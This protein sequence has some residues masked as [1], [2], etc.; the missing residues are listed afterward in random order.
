M[1]SPADLPPLP[2]IPTWKGIASMNEIERALLA[3]R[4]KCIDI[5]RADLE[6][7]VEKLQRFKDFAHGRLDEGGIPQDPPGEHRDAGCRIG[8][9]LDLIFSMLAQRDER[10][11]ELEHQLIL[12]N[13]AV[14]H[15]L[16]GWQD[17]GKRAE[18]AEARLETIRKLVD[19]QAEDDGLWFVAEHAPEAYL[20]QE[21]RKLHALIEENMD[22]TA[23]SP[24]TTSEGRSSGESEVGPP[25]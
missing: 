14:A 23:G 5:A 10:I 8:Q 17:E 20:Q 3:W 25:R 7:E 11:K 1:I 12:R 21:L 4:D 2:A 19:E 18:A 6:A 22:R 15:N 13:K 24:T 9:R 16:E